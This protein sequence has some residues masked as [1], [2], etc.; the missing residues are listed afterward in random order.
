[1][2]KVLQSV[3]VNRNRDDDA[4]DENR[5][6][7]LFFNVI[8]NLSLCLDVLFAP[9]FSGKITGSINISPIGHIHK[10]F[11]ILSSHQRE[12]YG[13]GLFIREYSD[14]GVMPLN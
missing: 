7:F 11:F 1:M 3:F 13:E 10:Y 14:Q 8:F 4:A 9:V 2:T 12:T 6:L 5:Y